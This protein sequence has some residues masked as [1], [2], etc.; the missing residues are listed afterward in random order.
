MTST[1]HTLKVLQELTRMFFLGEVNRE[2]AAY[3]H[4]LHVVGPDEVTEQMERNKEDF[5]DIDSRI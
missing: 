5:L 4:V 3:L 2:A 1:R